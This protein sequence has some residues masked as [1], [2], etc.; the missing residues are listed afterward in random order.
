MFNLR[1]NVLPHSRNP[2]NVVPLCT[3]LHRDSIIMSYNSFIVDRNSIIVDRRSKLLG[4]GVS[5]RTNLRLVFQNS[6]TTC[7]KLKK[8]NWKRIFSIWWKKPNMCV[9]EIFTHVMQFY[10]DYIFRKDTDKL[11]KVKAMRESSKRVTLGAETLPS[12]CCYTL[13]NTYYSYESC[14]I[15]TAFDKAYN[16]RVDL[17]AFKVHFLKNKQYALIC[18]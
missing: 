9:I 12:I 7:S 3:V 13:L 5:Y 18:I 14:F 15:S 11:E 2:L 10:S 16:W 4:G 17:Y 1:V 8:K 6:S